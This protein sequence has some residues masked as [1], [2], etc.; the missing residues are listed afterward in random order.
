MNRKLATIYENFSDYTELEIDKMIANLTDEERSILIDRYGNNFHIKNS[1]ENWEQKKTNVFYEKLVPKMKKMLSSNNYINNELQLSYNSNFDDIYSLIPILKSGASG[2]KICSKLN[3]NREE[4][5]DKLLKLK[6]LGVVT[7]QKYYSNGT[8]TYKPINKLKKL[9]ELESIKREQTIITDTYEDN[10][11]ILIISDLHFGNKLERLDLLDRVYNYCKRKDIHIIM[12]CGDLIDGVYTSGEQHISDRRKQIEYF[13]KNYPYDENILSFC[14]GGDHDISLFHRFS[15]DIIKAC[16]N[17]RHDIIIGGYNNAIVN[18]KNDQIHL[19][20]YIKGA[21]MLQTNAPIILQG[22]FH[23]YAT[24]FEK[25]K[26]KITVPTLSNII[27]QIPGALE[28]NLKFFKGYISSAIIKQLYFGSHDIVL[29]E[30][31]FDLLKYRNV[32]YGLIRNVEPFKKNKTK[33]EHVLIKR[34]ENLS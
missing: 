5:Y 3:I 34:K 6:N 20:H 13:I 4:L 21:Y 32:D 15:V 9:E 33:D 17:Y 24:A 11:K 12:C 19:F 23:K 31:H 2:Q 14:V 26:L 22:H 30:S 18:I 16:N 29:S 28:M 1:S 25:D 7:K 27:S 8:I 10:L